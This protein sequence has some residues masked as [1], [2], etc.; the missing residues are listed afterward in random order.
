MTFQI[1]ISEELK[2]KLAVLKRKD[3]TTYATL[4][5]KIFQITSSDKN[6][7]EHFKNLRTS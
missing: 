6:S 1:I 3:K 2:K 4:K 5:K 7:I